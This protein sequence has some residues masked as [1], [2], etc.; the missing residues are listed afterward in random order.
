MTDEPTALYRIFGDAEQL[1]YVGISNDFGTRWKQH[2]K[3][4]P[5]WN[6][7]KRLTVDEWYDS[8]ADA[9][10]AEAAAIRTE[11][12]KYNVVHNRP[13]P[14]ERPTCYW[15]DGEWWRVIAREPGWPDPAHRHLAIQS[16]SGDVVHAHSRRLGGK[17]SCRRGKCGDCPETWTWPP[18]DPTPV[19]IARPSGT[20]WPEEPFKRSRIHVELPVT[21]VRTSPILGESSAIP[22]HDASFADD[23]EMEALY[24]PP[25]DDTPDWGWWPDGAWWRAWLRLDR[26]AADV[27]DAITCPR[28]SATEA[29]ALI[30]AE[31][32]YKQSA[33][34]V[35]WVQDEGPHSHSADPAEMAYCRPF[36]AHCDITCASNNP[37]V[38]LD[39]GVQQEFL[40]VLIAAGRCTEVRLGA[41]AAAFGFSDATEAQVVGH[42]LTRVAVGDAD[43]TLECIKVLHNAA[44]TGA[45]S[46]PAA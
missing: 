16:M 20:G 27:V 41:A 19:V 40:N 22:R 10:A 24:S 5:W 36:S 23:S 33:W 45:T 17:H 3:A 43:T 2:A 13:A 1:L 35:A 25:A 42:L 7:K 46:K 37:D 31:G 8:R 38:H 6:E 9:L 15:Y 29:F 39:V 12:P 11:K 21:S 44:A 26:D 18:F 4:Q 30:L 14:P 32:K 28:R 34:P